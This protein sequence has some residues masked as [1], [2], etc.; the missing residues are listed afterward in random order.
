MSMINDALKRAKQAQTQ[1]PEVPRPEQLEL[2]PV[3]S[4]QTA[5]RGNGVIVPVVLAFGALLVMFFAWKWVGRPQSAPPIEARA[6]TS[7]PLSGSEAAQPAASAAPQL[8]APAPALPAEPAV[9]N[10]PVAAVTPPA[11]ATNAVAAVEEAVAPRVVGLKLQGVVCNKS[12]SSAMV[13][14]KTLFVGDRILDYR[15]V[16]VTPETA[17]LVGLGTTNVLSLG[18][19]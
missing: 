10:T 1:A 9:T 6:Q 4:F 14:G 7:K 12:R 11:P 16:A 8:P 2:R 19:Q 17:T 18:D 13:N 3:E 15:L 5:G